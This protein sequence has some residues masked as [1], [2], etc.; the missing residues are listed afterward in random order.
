MTFALDANGILQVTAKDHGTGR[1]ESVTINNDI[2]GRLSQDE[3]D[4]MLADANRFADEDKEARERIEARNGLESL[5]FGVK[6]QVENDEGGLGNLGEEDKDAIWVAVKEAQAWLH[7][8]AATATAE[9][10]E[11][12]K[13]AFSRVVHPI[14]SRF[15]AA[16]G[17]GNPDGGNEPMA[18]DEL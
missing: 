2:N 10:F 13:E 1:Q 16:S 6:S 14:T 4:R 5:V 9:G 12:Q 7:D 15:Y 3:I 17:S 18:H 11:E 8:M